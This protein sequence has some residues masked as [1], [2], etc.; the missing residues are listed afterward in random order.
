MAANKRLACQKRSLGVQGNISKKKCNHV[1]TDRFWN[2]ANFFPT[3]GENVS[4][5]LITLHFTCPGEEFEQKFFSV[6]VILL[7]IFVTSELKN[8]RCLAEKVPQGRQDCILSDRIKVLRSFYWKE[9]KFPWF[10]DV[11]QK[12]FGLL[13]KVSGT[14]VKTVIY[15]SSERFRWL[16]FLKKNTSFHH[17][18]TLTAKSYPT[19]V[20]TFRQAFQNFNLVVQGNI[21]RRNIFSRTKMSNILLLWAKIS[22][23]FGK[24]KF[25]Q[26]CQN[27]ILCL[28]RKVS[29][30]FLGEKV[31]LL[32][33]RF[34]IAKK[35]TTFGRK[36]MAFVLKMQSACPREQFEGKQVVE[37]TKLFI[38][39][40]LC[41][42]KFR[43]V[44]KQK[45]AEFSR[46]HYTCPDERF[47]DL[48]PETF[49]S[50]SPPDFEQTTMRLFA[51]RNQHGLQNCILRLQRNVLRIFMKKTSFL[52][53]TIGLYPRKKNIELL[54]AKL[55]HARQ[56]AV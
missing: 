6:K 11:E 42:G 16:F 45:S 17:F 31:S 32:H 29:M 12:T 43:I 14:L 23:K 22:R 47:E 24:K 7:F 21:L 9:I 2:P 54:A 26:G 53:I 39:F 8:L 38:N 37:R 52:F 56:N 41:A 51:G 55:R 49:F 28:Q 15:V 1:L 27:C 20:E 50:L 13:A 46:M 5:R 48:L 18:P 33:S 19:F 44:G 4:A 36:T 3:F 30:S 35:H 10:S 25:N 40:V 34:L